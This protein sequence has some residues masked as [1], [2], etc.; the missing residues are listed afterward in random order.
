MFPKLEKVRNYSIE[1]GD[2]NANVGKEDIYRKTA[3]KHCKVNQPTR[4]DIG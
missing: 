4:T 3:G 2:Y 1:M